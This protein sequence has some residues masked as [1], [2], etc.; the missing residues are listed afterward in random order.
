MENNAKCEVFVQNPL[1][2]FS[3]AILHALKVLILENF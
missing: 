1:S 2:V 3:M